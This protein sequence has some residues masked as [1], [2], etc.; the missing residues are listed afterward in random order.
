MR[1]TLTP[2]RLGHGTS[3]RLAVGI[4]APVGGSP[5]PLT[6]LD[7]LY[8]ENFGIGL[9]GLGIETCAQARLQSAGPAGCPTD[10]VMGY[11]QAQ[12]EIASGAQITRVRAKLTVLRAENAHGHIAMLFD[13]QGFSAALPNIVFSGLVVAARRP[14]D[15]IHINVPLVSSQAGGGDV[16]LVGLT[17]I[18]G[19]AAG[20]RYTETV[21]GRTVSYKPNGVLLPSSCPRGGFRFAASFVFQGGHQGS[22]KTTVRC[23][24]PGRA[25]G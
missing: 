9:S 19:P 18:I 7:L 23:P 12:G 8:P 15:E 1:A 24:P 20:L 4:R 11:G 10:S 14:F 13:A 22:A 2:E 5:A 16:A 3:I 6:Q 21:H 17:A 25:R